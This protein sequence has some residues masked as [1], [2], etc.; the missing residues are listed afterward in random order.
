MPVMNADEGQTIARELAANAEQRASALQRDL[1]ELDKT[2]WTR[3]RHPGGTTGAGAPR[4]LLCK[5]RMIINALGVGSK[6]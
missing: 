1:I 2:Q 3:G 4:Q 6:R 5:S